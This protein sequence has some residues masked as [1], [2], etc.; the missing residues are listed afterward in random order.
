MLQQRQKRSESR[1]HVADQAKFG[2][3]AKTDMIGLDIDLNGACAALLRIGIDPRHGRAEDQQRVAV[4]HD[5]LAGLRPQMS[6]AACCI[7]RIIG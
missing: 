6:D 7:G 5:P 4:L 2:R 1:L 3:I